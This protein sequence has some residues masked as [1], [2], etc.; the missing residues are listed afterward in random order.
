MGDQTPCWAVVATV[1]EPPALVQA[2]VAWHLSLGATEVFLYFDRP[3]DPAQS[4]FVDLPQVSVTVCDDGYWQAISKIR[5]HR[6]QVR[7]MRNARQA[8][9]R[10]GS[11]WLLHADA[12]EFVW[13]DRPV[14]EVLAQADPAIE[15]LM[16]PVAERIFTGDLPDQMVLEGPFRRP[17]SGGPKAG[18]KRYG[19]GFDMTHRGLTGHS[20]GKSFVRAGRDLNMSIHRPRPRDKDE[21][22][23]R[24]WAP[25]L[26]LLHFDG[27][28]P[29]HWIYKLTR[30][31][32]ALVNR[33]GMP[34]SPHRRAQADAL[35]ID[36]EGATAL[37]DLLKVA[38]DALTAKLD[39]DDLL[40][41][42]PFDP[43]VAFK[44][45]F[46]DADLD[47]SMATIDA[48]LRREKAQVLDF[49]TS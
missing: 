35:L 42:P 10:T 3:D 22:L 11:D 44:S 28:T 34:P 18:R 38:D 19:P 23:A 30:M 6:H 37:H 14:A 45:Y 31:A 7:Q 8:Y 21:N 43:S 20:L 15:A 26:T 1:D 49:L 24:V 47:L 13:P 2:F 40:V 4:L 32:E 5:P 48:W 16:V 25:A 39:A 27:L 9:Q 29:L 36:P 17:F 12:D 46:P 33:D 41:A